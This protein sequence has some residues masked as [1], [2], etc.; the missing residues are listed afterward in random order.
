MTRKKI[1]TADERLA[2]MVADLHKGKMYSH[3][4]NST[5]LKEASDSIID[6]IA[7]VQSRLY[8]QRQPWPAKDDFWAK[9]LRESAEY[10]FMYGACE[11]LPY[12]MGTG[13]YLTHD[14]DILWDI[15]TAKKIAW[16]NYYRCVARLVVMFAA[17]HIPYVQSASIDKAHERAASAQYRLADMATHQ[18]AKLYII[19]PDEEIAK[20]LVR[21][22]LGTKRLRVQ[23]SD[24]DIDFKDS[25]TYPVIDHDGWMN[26]VS[27]QL[28]ADTDW[29]REP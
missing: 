21:Q 16:S 12:L 28:G 18:L 5:A 20:F 27:R 22:W 26:Y 24:F 25:G 19:D 6:M 10:S 11:A 13:G 3:K 2:A 7:L 29:S 1:P 23:Q 8:E 4:Y 14:G 17:A 15:A 9:A